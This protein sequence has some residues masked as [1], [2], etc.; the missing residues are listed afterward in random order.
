MSEE[1]SIDYDF[2]EDEASDFSFESDYDDQN[3][4]MIDTP[5]ESP[6]DKTDISKLAKFKKWTT[7]EFINENFINAAVKLQNLQLPQCNL[8]DL[9]I[10][11]HQLKWQSEEVINNYYDNY[12]KL[13]NDCGIPKVK[14]N[15]IKEKLEYSCPICCE[16]YDNI[17]T[18]QLSCGHEYCINCYHSY[19]KTQLTNGQL[20][21]CIDTSCNLTIPHLL[22][23]EIFDLFSQDVRDPAQDFFE[24]PTANSKYAHNMLL[25][26]AARSYINSK[27]S[28]Y[29][30]CPA[31]DCENLVELVDNYALHL[32]NDD[33][34][35][36]EYLSDEESTLL[37]PSTN[38]VKDKSKSPSVD[39]PIDISLTPIVSCGTD[40]QFCYN[41][42]YE[43]HL[44]CP[45]NIVRSWI[46]KCKDDSETANWIEANTHNCPKCLNSIEKNGGCNHMTCRTCN[47]EFCWIC[48]KEWS[49][50]G[51]QFFKCNN[52]D[53]SEKDAIELNQKQKRVSLQR[54]LH[55]YKRF[56]VHESSMKGDMKAL[57]KINQRMESFMSEQSKQNL[58]NLSWTDVQFLKDAFKAL[59]NGRK[60]LKWS[61]CFGFYM[62][63]LIFAEV[64]EQTQEHL[65]R[66][67]EDLSKIVEEI[68][69]KKNN[70]RSTELIMKNKKALISL[71]NAVT[72]GQQSLIQCA[73][74][75]LK[76][77]RLKFD[78]SI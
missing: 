28:K 5:I 38:N 76:E 25:S 55:Y 65:N 50:H 1:G 77:E 44:P 56:A 22:T 36:D 9:L 43:N 12:D 7:K 20:I 70:D 3:D 31:P 69:D 19:L 53:K 48:F 72:K 59:T 23:Q 41:C 15:V 29:K 30:W 14:N 71:T 8:E 60:T 49:I 42:Q 21:R 2:D 16:E 32:D 67:V 6:K 57:D 39:R 66:V 4:N 73:E 47:Y 78:L 27:K 10:M 68:N 74:S 45:C 34:D 62:K 13:M 33:D 54:Y 64:F 11:L 18:F 24:V 63:E 46:K 61:Y 75:G 58:S 52:F 51:S 26:S 35:F 37:D 17:K 40:H